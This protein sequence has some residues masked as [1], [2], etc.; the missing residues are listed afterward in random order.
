VADKDAQFYAG[1][2]K[3]S[4]KRLVETKLATNRA[5][6]IILSEEEPDDQKAILDILFAVPP[7]AS[8][9]ANAKALHHNKVNLKDPTERDYAALVK[10]WGRSNDEVKK[11]FKL[12]I[13]SKGKASK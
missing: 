12:F 10:V 5:G 7:K 6:L 4:K 9:I 1:L 13:A 11:Q 3:D 8:N 2:T